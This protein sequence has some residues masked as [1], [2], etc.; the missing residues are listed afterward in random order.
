M[1]IKESWEIAGHGHAEE[2]ACLKCLTIYPSGHVNII[3]GVCFTCDKPSV[4][5]NNLALTLPGEF[6][7]EYKIRRDK[8]VQTNSVHDA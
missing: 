2:S 7:R 3:S 1:A 6:I 5:I 4:S 8:R